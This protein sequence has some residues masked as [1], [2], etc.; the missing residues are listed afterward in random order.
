VPARN[1]EGGRCVRRKTLIGDW[2]KLH[3][4]ANLRA[5]AAMP[6]GAM[7]WNTGTIMTNNPGIGQSGGQ[8]YDV[9]R[10][11]QT[12]LGQ[13]AEGGI[14]VGAAVIKE[15]LQNADD[16]GATEVQVILDERQ[17]CSALPDE[18]RPLLS[19]A[20]LVRNNSHFRSKDDVESEDQ[21]DFAA[22]CDVA[23]G[24]KRFQATAAGRFGIGFNSV[25]FL[26][27][28]PVLFSRREVHVFD[29]LHRIFP[30]NGWRFTLDDFRAAAQSEAG[31]LK[32]VLE[33]ILPKAALDSVLAFGAIA[34]D[35]SADYRQTLFR[36]PL[37]QQH[38]GAKPLYPDLFTSQ[39]VRLSL[40]D[41]MSVQAAQAILFLKNVDRIQFGILNEGGFASTALIE[42]TAHPREFREF[43][44]AVREAVNQIALGKELKCAYP[45]TVTFRRWE[46]EGKTEESV[47]PFHVRH[48]ARFDDP[49]LLTFRQRLQK[50]EERAV[51]WASIGIPL[52]A[53][54]IHIDGTDAPQWRV[55]LPLLEPGPS[56]CIF[57]AALFVGP[58]RQRVEFRTDGS[59]DAKRKTDWNRLLVEKGVVPLLREAS[60]DMLDLVPKLIEDD[61]KEYLALFPLAG[62]N[63]DPQSLAQHLQA[64]FSDEPWCLRL[65]DLWGETIELLIGGENGTISLDMIP[66][67]LA[68][69]R[70]R[71]HSLSCE[72]RRFIRWSLGDALRA[73]LG[74]QACITVQREVSADVAK[75]V[76]GHEEA[77]NPRDLEKLIPRSAESGAGITP[78]GISGLWAF[79]RSGDGTPLRYDSEVL[80]I[81]QSDDKDLPIHRAFRSSQLSFDGVEWVSAKAGL[82]MVPAEQKRQLQN[83]GEADEAAAL[84]L[85]RRVATKYG[86]DCLATAADI[87]PVVDFL[88]GVDAV[89]LPL[90]LHLGF[91]VRTAHGTVDRRSMGTVLLR[92]E[93]QSDEESDLWE[94]LFRRNFPQVDPSFSWE[95]HRLLKR[96]PGLVAALSTA[97]CEVAIPDANNAL[98]IFVKA[99][100]SAPERFHAVEEDVNR[101]KVKAHAEKT[102]G[103][104]L[105]VACRHWDR[106]DE[107]HR[108]TLQALPLHRT[109]DGSLVSL[110]TPTGTD[111]FSVKARFRLQSQDDIKD[112]PITVPE[113]RLLHSADRTVVHFYRQRLGLEEHG[114][115]AVLKDVLRQIGDPARDNRSLLAYLARHYSETVQQLSESTEPGHR[116]DAAEMKNLLADARVVPCLD[117]E[118]RRTQETVGAWQAAERLSKQGWHRKDV[119]PLLTALFDELNIGAL[120]VAVRDSL[121]C[122]CELESL[123]I[124]QLACQAV[125]SESRD[126]SLAQRFK[127]LIDNW[128]DRP[129]DAA[130]AEALSELTVPSLTGR[131]PF[132]EAEMLSQGIL[133]LPQPILRSLAPKA[134]DWQALADEFDL[135]VAKARQVL[136]HIGIAAVDAGVCDTRLRS[137]FTGIW[138]TLE[139]PNRLKLLEYVG[140]RAD[141]AKALAAEVTT[142]PV[143]LIADGRWAS[144]ASVV[145]P[146]WLD[147]K[148]T[149]LPAGAQPFRDGVPANVLSLWDAWC[150]IADFGQI[151]ETILDHIQ[152]MGRQRWSSAAA[153][154]Y[155]WIDRA[156]SWS[157]LPPSDLQTALGDLPWVCAERG[158][159]VGFLPPTEVIVHPGAQVLKL[160]FWVATRLPANVEKM[161]PTPGFLKAPEPSEE[162]IAA[163]VECLVAANEADPQGLVSVYSLIAEMLSENDRLTPVWDRLAATQPVFHLFR[164]SGQP[165]TRLGIFLGSSRHQDDIGSQILCLKRSQENLPKG[166]RQTFQRLGVPESPT[167]EQAAHALCT[168][169]GPVKD[170][171]ATYEALVALL[172]D[173]EVE[174]DSRIRVPA[175][176]GTFEPLAD[177]Y[178]DEELGLPNRVEPDARCRLIHAQDRTTRR[179]TEW[180]S[181]RPRSPVLHLRKCARRQITESPLADETSTMSQVLGPW[182]DLLAELHRD[183]SVFR[184]Q[185]S[186]VMGSLPDLAINVAAVDRIRVRYQFPSGDVLDQ[187]LSWGGPQA[188]HDGKSTIFVQQA[189][190]ATARGDTAADTIVTD[191]LIASEVVDLLRTKAAAARDDAA[192]VAQDL[193]LR[194]LERP[195]VMLALMREDNQ[196]HFFH[197]YHDQVA[198]PEF[199]RLFEEYRKTSSR[200]RRGQELEVEMRQI[201]E[202][203]Y[204]D[205]RRDQIRGYGYDEFSV[206]AELVQNAEDAYLQRHRLGMDALEHRPVAFRYVAHEGHGQSLQVQHYGRQFNY[207]RHGKCQDANYS[208]DVE[209]VLRSA[210]SFKPHTTAAT[211]AE[212]TVGRFGLGFKCVYLITDRPVI[213][214]G[215]WHFAIEAGCLPVEVPP[216]AEIPVDA[217]RIELPLREDAELLRKDAS[218]KLINLLPFLREVDSIE[219]CDA[220]TETRL[221]LRVDEKWSCGDGVIGELVSIE[222]ASLHRG[223]HVRFL[224]LRQADHAGQIA[225]CLA[226]DG[227]PATW[228][229]AFEYDAF[230]VLPLRARLNCGVG[231]SSRFEVQSGRTHLVDQDANA[232]R[233]AEV[234]ALLRRVPTALRKCAKVGSNH[235]D[236][237][238]RFWCIWRWQSGDHETEQLRFDLAKTLAKLPDDD[239]VVPTLDGESC[240][241]LNDTPAFYFRGVPERVRKALMATGMPV[242]DADGRQKVLAPSNTVPDDFVTAYLQTCRYSGVAPAVNLVPVDWKAIGSACRESAWLA[243]H[244]DVL[245]AIATAFP[246]RNWR[247]VLEWLRECPVAGRDGND[248]RI[249][250]CPSDL[251]APDFDGMSHLPRRLLTVLGDGYDDAAVQLL[252]DAGLQMRPTPKSMSKWIAEGQLTETECNGLLKYLVEE[253]RFRQCWEMS[254][255]FKTR[256]F[257]S[258]RGKLSTAD[259]L[260]AGFI[261][262]K[263]LC[264]EVFKSWLGLPTA[265]PPPQPPPSP[266]RLTSQ[267]A[268]RWLN[269]LFEWWLAN[270]QEWTSRYEQRVYPCGSPFPVS[271]DFK[272]G[273]RR[274]RRNWLSLFMLGAFHTMGRQTPEQ[275]RGFLKLCEQKGWLDVFADPQ[276]DAASWMRVLEGYLDEKVDQADY[277]QWISHFVRIFHLSRWLPQYVETFL[278]TN[279]IRKP[280]SLDHILAPRASAIFQGGGPDAPPITRTLGTG[281]CFV[282]RE[283]ARKQVINEPH[284]WRHCYV[285]ALRVRKVLW[286]AGCDKIDVAPGGGVAVSETIHK[287]LVRHLGEEK[288]IFGGSFD[289]PLLAAADGEG[290][291][292]QLPQNVDEVELRDDN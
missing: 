1:T 111:L 267:Q 279:R 239:T 30:V 12:F 79:S 222:G 234:A 225:I 168:I 60:L 238:R 136:E 289:L 34:S 290:P 235:A 175:C 47:W 81:V 167:A 70:D 209:G 15:L 292:T 193:I 24:H 16:A 115:A 260:A 139:K 146:K 149:N 119:G 189:L 191:S 245:N 52:A 212:R 65:H 66:D 134:V 281:A 84:Q 55:F 63:K 223:N 13:M 203:N 143:V 154:L 62:E 91:L 258:Q 224:R 89:R 150:G 110:C 257:P 135:S 277:Y 87:V 178:W 3:I 64:C 20:L 252:K 105:A 67:W 278:A 259:A 283:L 109:A 169:S 270:G 229:E 72:Q 43:E 286:I 243:D 170:H 137:G 53:E 124:G 98:S 197:Q 50:N 118:W 6:D 19:P 99:C 95:I 73:R 41:E 129:S 106:L 174:V 36:L 32:T 51:P 159:E 268:T 164:G 179:L 121:S 211:E 113:C 285:P 56:G 291:G 86:H 123:D 108:L 145:C 237:F 161:T 200:S 275:H 107:E 213:H 128:E 132:S 284:V 29:L 233:F 18:Y 152:T 214:S 236:M 210:G 246:D 88:V 228:D 187:S 202:R 272:P 9:A 280:F 77:P 192:A 271:A 208:R 17:H 148:P 142:E 69:Y 27:D 251:L 176:S 194:H 138:R 190:T 101:P 207:W 120:D 242:K 68:A 78:G 195:S 215:W 33:R 26:T 261:A 8:H 5:L 216:P 127:V 217:T 241:P 269:D 282:M 265:S 165:V 163:L 37:R 250:A 46:G 177:C 204:V 10:A 21:D 11:I 181:L 14:R 253:Q 287:F 74:S 231:I 240:L 126:L 54:A 104:L 162:N 96:Q 48:S 131:T 141:L 247:D 122:F 248:Q 274:D 151:L 80:Y 100:R 82:P 219:L 130:R 227:L 206:F 244:P 232:Q 117:G 205:A 58:S 221:W 90:D 93:T 185:I 158:A 256:W 83:I 188:A 112:A 25:Y 59:D 23:S 38:T 220:E 156:A 147:T 40:L 22:I 183:G 198:D 57:S 102:A 39:D 166:L 103:V 49:N 75:R 85:L 171:R 61:P 276:I 263:I 182:R 184:E 160:R 97:D 133:H 42:A 125:T 186:E 201:M 94:G 218:M 173:S 230:V 288:A 153:E 144:P 2:A 4:P 71:F 262:H 157:G 76:L 226:D 31:P 28:T 254:A 7:I 199:A 92:P 35:L 249:R 172:V 255:V 266:T 114:R 180:M 264:D 155:G 116:S 273:D 196:D 140:G 45:R 44:F